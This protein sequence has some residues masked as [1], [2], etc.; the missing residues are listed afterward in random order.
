MHFSSRPKAAASDNANDSWGG[1][2]IREIYTGAKFDG[3]VEDEG[4]DRHDSTAEE[5]H[6]TQL[7][8]STLANDCSIYAEYIS[9][10]LPLH[11]GHIWCNGNFA[12]DL[13]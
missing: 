5:H 1:D 11:L 6:Q 2:Y 4:N 10:N 13:V 3:T 12:E 9:L 7:L 8:K